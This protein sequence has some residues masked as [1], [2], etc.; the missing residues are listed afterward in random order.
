MTMFYQWQLLGLIA[1]CLASLV[2]EKYVLRKASV[3]EQT[4]ENHAPQPIVSRLAGRYLLV[5]AIVMGADWLQGPYIYSL[6]REQYGLPERLVAFLF[7]LGFLTAGVAAPLVGVWADQYGRKRM[8]TVF[9]LIY[10]L[11]CVFIQFPSLALLF[12]GRLLGGFGTAI[13]FSSFESWLVTSAN[14]LTLSSRDLSRILG[15]ATLINSVAAAIAGIVSNK[16]VE[17]THSFASPFIA[18]GFL[19]L[20][21]WILIVLLWSENYGA[22]GSSANEL[23]DWKR[24]AEAWSIVRADKRLLVLGFTQTC[25]EGSMYLFVFLWVPFLQ[26]ATPQT[27]GG[28][29][30]G[31]IFS[32]F[33]VS[34]TLGSVIYTSIVSLSR[35]DGSALYAAGP[36][37][38]SSTSGSAPS[39]TPSPAVTSYE[40]AITLHAKLSS[41]VCA[42]SA[43]A[44]LL[45]IANEHEH[46][47]FWAFCVFEACVGMYYPVQGMLRGRLIEDEHRAT[48]S[49]LFR[50]PLNIFVFVALL[51][52]V[53]SARR[54]VLS[55]CAGLL[56]LSASVTAAVFIRHG[57]GPAL[58]TLRTR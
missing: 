16:L 28:L 25:F 10:T 39:D 32:S 33:M 50:V 11:A 30:L 48:L 18:S 20:L 4:A 47:R 26:E 38:D 35:L 55:A 53:S 5:Y 49:S 22:A 8:C 36:T 41:V 7:V 6:Y 57:R 56:L 13:L 29:P 45:S 3:A 46:P 21:G 40:R 27:P 14:N 12:S 1:A 44:F 34:M 54:V 19:L 24:L 2:F 51:T 9:C 43:A 31:Y 15:R 58:A 17:K 52:G 37:S 42:A 23:L